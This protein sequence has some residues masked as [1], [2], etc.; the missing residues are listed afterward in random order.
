VTVGRELEFLRGI[1]GRGAPA[2]L[3]SLVEDMWIEE[4]LRVAI[5]DEPVEN[6]LCET[7]RLVK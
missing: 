4:E 1:K 7:I 2:V 5:M 3:R 6:D